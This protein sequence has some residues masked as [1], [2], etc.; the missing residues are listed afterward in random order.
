MSKRKTPLRQP[1]GS[2][3]DFETAGYVEGQ[4]LPFSRTQSPEAY[5]RWLFEFLRTDLRAL[6]PVQ[7]HGMRANL[8][9]FVDPG[10]IKGQ[11]WSTDPRR[12][13]ERPNAVS[14]PPIE[15]LE[16]MQQDARAG[17]QR[18]RENK[19]YVL[20]E[21]IGYGIAC[22][23]HHIVRIGRSGTFKDLFRAAL[24]D[25]VQAVWGSLYECPRCHALF[26]KVGKQKYCSPTCGRRTHWDAFKERRA[27]RD[28]HREYTGRVRKRLGG[29]VK[30]SA[31]PRRE[32]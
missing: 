5:D 6:T 29:K 28:H 24:M 17:L 1:M 13:A 32:K 16:E 21:G 20:E 31:R 7:L 14:L 10:E 30:V 12:P 22:A 26:V 19:W 15:V 3:D 18:L 25:T 2:W 8:W 4:T 23:G 27:A 9:A 11:S